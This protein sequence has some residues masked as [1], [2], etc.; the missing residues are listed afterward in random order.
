[1]CREGQEFQGSLNFRHGQSRIGKVLR[2][3][4]GVIILT[5]L[6][7]LL[8]CAENQSS[9]AIFFPAPLPSI[10]DAEFVSP[11]E[12]PELKATVYL[13]HEGVL[14]PGQRAELIAVRWQDGKEIARLTLEARNFEGRLPRFPITAVGK[15]AWFNTSPP[16]IIHAESVFEGIA[17]WDLGSGDFREQKIFSLYSDQGV[18]A[19]NA[20]VGGI[21][22]L[23]FLFYE[24]RRPEEPTR[25]DLMAL[26]LETGKIQLLAKKTGPLAAIPYEQNWALFGDTAWESGGAVRILKEGEGLRTEEI[27]VPFLKDEY[28]LIGRRGNVFFFYHAGGIFRWYLNDPSGKFEEL[29]FW[30]EVIPPSSGAGWCYEQA[31]SGYLF[32]FDI[33]RG[34][35]GT[36][37]QLDTYIADLVNEK[38]CRL[39]LEEKKAIPAPW[40]W[41]D[42]YLTFPSRV[43][44]EGIP[45]GVNEEERA[46]F[47]VRQFD[48]GKPGSSVV[49]VN[50]PALF[51]Q[52][53]P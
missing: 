20:F 22:G 32:S 1:M 17:C 12:V 39:S 41:N 3:L 13:F 5:G 52:Q 43:S 40:S 25:G 42:Y 16:P 8:S 38:I 28:S 49:M 48:P 23:P 46:Y 26:E 9:Q 37:E 15:K 11:L 35:V 31:P 47:P 7:I 4:L 10:P 33:R 44:Q 2:A 14:G 27:S 30:R 29:T 21:Q 51:A 50:L 36:Q 24:D 45:S 53:T 34:P 18:R 19:E 6:L